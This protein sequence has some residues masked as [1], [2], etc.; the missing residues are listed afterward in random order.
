M[1][2]A[3]QAAGPSTDVYILEPFWDKQRYEAA[4][5]SLQATSL[6]F[7]CMAN[8]NSKMYRCGELADA[9]ERA[10]FDLVEAWHNLG[11]NDYSLLRCRIRP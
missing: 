3:R 6:Y 9:V 4:S 5:Y 8:G 11:S 10:G 1:E 2:K 7:T